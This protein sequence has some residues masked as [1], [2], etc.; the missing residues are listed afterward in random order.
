V[1]YI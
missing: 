1:R